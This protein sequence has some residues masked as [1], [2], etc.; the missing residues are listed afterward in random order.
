[1]KV[2]YTFFIAVFLTSISFAFSYD[3]DPFKEFLLKIDRYRDKYTSE[4][5][6]IHTDKPYYSIG[7]TIWFKSYVV[8]GQTNQLSDLSKI[9]YVDLISEKDSIKKA[10]RLPIVSGLSWGD[11]ILADS[12]VEGNYR[13]RAYTNWM[14]NFDEAYFYDKVIKIGNSSTNVVSNVS[15]TFS[16]TGIKENVEANITYT[17]LKNNPLIGKAVSYTVKLDN[18]DVLKG[19]GETDS[20]GKLQIKFTNAQPFILKSGKLNTNIMLDSKTQIR[21]TYPIKATSDAVDVQFFPESGTV[22]NGIWSRIAFKAVGADGLSRKI[23]GTVIDSTNSEVAQFSSG[24]AGMG[25]LYLTPQKGQ[26]YTALVR[27]EDGSEKRIS[28]PKAADSGY[29]L[30]ITGVDKENLTVKIYAINQTTDQELIL[31]GQSNGG[32]SYVSK[33]KSNNGVLS[34]LLSKKLFPRGIVQ[35]TV[36]NSAYQPLAERLVFVR[37][38]TEPLVL[39]VTTDKPVYKVREKVMLSLDALDSVGKPAAGV[40]SIAITDESNVPFDD[41]SETTILSNLLLTSDLKGYVEK[42][43]YYFTDVSAEKDKALDNLMLTQGWRK[44]EWKSITSGVLPAIVFKPEKDISLSG[45]VYNSNGTPAAAGKVTVLSAGGNGM[46]L[47]TLTDATGGFNFDKLVFNDNTSFVVQARNA[48]GKKNVDIQIDRNPLPL[49]A[50][51]INAPSAEINVNQSLISYLT[52]FNEQLKAMG[53]GGFFNRNIVLQEV[54]IKT[55]KPLV[56]HSS[57]LNGPGNADG[58]IVADDLKNCTNL[59]F[60]L[61]GR[62][63]GLIV[64]NGAA[65]LTRTMGSTFGGGGAMLLIVDGSYMDPTY[66]SAIPPTDVETIEILKNVGH[67]ALYGMQGANGVLIIT[68][69]TGER[70]LS[71]RSYAAGILNYTPQGYYSSRQFYSP[72]YDVSQNTSV[73]DLR[74][75]TIFWAPNIVTTENGKTSVEFFTSDKPATYKAVIEGI[76]F[77][78]SVIRQVYRFSVK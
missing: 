19:K 33:N 14:R 28:L 36:F 73:S 41:I 46:V 76:D 31:I 30:T 26:V 45:K 4:K 3:E 18:R 48:K 43:N 71:A 7:D 34:A 67:L 56:A 5:I 20:N 35:F 2:K 66:I 25:S 78:G 37:H 21:N 68:T 15:Y 55:V 57:N 70:S 49:V 54:K 8:S 23:T 60:C 65:Y 72:N 6:H 22:I 51:S 59:A 61:F 40:F 58:V 69:K 47:D 16:K 24:F 42:P 50:K 39:T 13:I 12:L 64:K 52:N 9:L 38:K 44:F 77:N 53:K 10:L 27:F 62:V 32:V 29:V 11:F 63:P 75:Y 17:D 74:S 1:M